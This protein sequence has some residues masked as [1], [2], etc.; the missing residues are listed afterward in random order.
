ML[1]DKNTARPHSNSSLAEGTAMTLKT[2]AAFILCCASM[3]VGA[4]QLYKCGNTYSQTPCGADAQQK[5]VFSAA[6]DAPAG[7]GGANLS[8][9]DLCV[10]RATDKI[11]GPNPDAI[12]VQ[13][14]GTR[15]AEVTTHAGQSVMAHRYQFDVQI[16]Q[17]SGVYGPPVRWSCWVSEDQRR[18][19]NA[20]G[21]M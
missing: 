17:N 21:Q 3:S 9:Y 14:V 5:K 1:L 13:P 10:A 4:Q 20:Y 18:V 6:P 16:L 19:L 11:R 7:T 2:I 8:G 15:V 12:R